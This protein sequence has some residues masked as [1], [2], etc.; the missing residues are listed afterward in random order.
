M[1]FYLLVYLSAS[2]WRRKLTIVRMWASGVLAYCGV[3][4]EAGQEA[5]TR[6][7]V[8]TPSSCP[9]GQHSQSTLELASSIITLYI[10]SVFK[11]ALPPF[12]WKPI[13]LSWRYNIP[14]M[15]L[16]SFPSLLCCPHLLIYTSF[17]PLNCLPLLNDCVPRFPQ[18][19]ACLRVSRML[20]AKGPSTASLST[21]QNV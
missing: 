2:P 1:T 21:R 6:H 5:H 16:L 7:T 15:S 18:T 17:C 11:H 10:L 3:F 4:G 19:C 14:Q 13:V 9:F 12:V 8:T 20:L